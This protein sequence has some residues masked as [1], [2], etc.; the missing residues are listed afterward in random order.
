M[1]YTPVSVEFS[2]GAIARKRKRSEPPAR[3]LSGHRIAT[4]MGWIDTWA[5]RRPDIGI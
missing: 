5:E 2:R 4:G 1:E 3:F